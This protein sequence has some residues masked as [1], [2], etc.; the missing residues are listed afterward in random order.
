MGGLSDVIDK[1]LAH[2]MPFQ[3]LVLS[4]TLRDHYNIREENTKKSAKKPIDFQFTEDK[5]FKNDILC[6]RH[7]KYGLCT[8]V[9][10]QKTK[11]KW[12][13]EAFFGQAK[14]K[15]QSS[16][17]LK[18][19]QKDLSQ[20]PL[21]MSLIC[22]GEHKD[23]EEDEEIQRDMKNRHG[24]YQVSGQM[25]GL[26]YSDIR[27]KMGFAM[28]LKEIMDPNTTDKKLE[29][30]SLVHVMLARTM[31]RRDPGNAPA[32]GSRLPYIFKEV[33]NENVLQ[34]KRAEHPDYVKTHPEVKADP[35]YYLQRQLRNQITQLLA[36]VVE[37]S[38]L[39]RMF[40]EKIQKYIHKKNGQ[41]EISDFFKFV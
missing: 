32:S 31:K 40:D 29:R 13:T 27:K 26:F 11:F 38:V 4:K 17:S 33:K 22:I 24:K 8:G 3:K 21:T 28:S 37:E 7:P 36:L 35:V 30:F 12:T 39:D 16:R 6:F 9:V 34:Y 23:D 5:I 2:K 41:K 1:M 15:K 20:F 14:R 10:Y 19:S 25:C 18:M